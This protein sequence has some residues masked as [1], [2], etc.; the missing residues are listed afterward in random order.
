VTSRLLL[1]LALVALIFALL[2]LNQDESALAG[3]PA[4]PAKQTGYYLRDST[5]TEFGVDG[6]PR[7]QLGVHA[8]TEDPARQVVGLESVALDYF[9]LPGQ[10]WRLTAERGQIATGSET[11]ELEGNVIM[12]GERQALPEPAI[13]RTEHMTLDTRA[14][15]AST[16]APVTLGL[17]VYALSA[18]G[19]RADLKA[20][21]L[22][23]ESAVNG[24]FNP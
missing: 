16:D 9:A 5:I 6:K 22:R 10:R 2:R 14:E 17:G 24:R 19:L 15:L 8:A 23:L 12:T 7:L 13:I 18:T 21:T 3:R 20:E 1:L 4:G 11:V